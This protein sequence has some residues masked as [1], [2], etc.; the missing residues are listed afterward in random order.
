[1]VSDTPATK[2]VA[3]TGIEHRVVTY[4]KVDTAE[5]AARARGVPLAALVKTLVLRL[6]GDDYRLV[7]ISG[8]RVIDWPK[9]RR[10]LGVTRVS[11]AD[12]DALVAVTG[13]VRGTVT[14]FG[15]T[16]G[17]P[18]IV[19][20]SVL[21]HDEVSLGGGEHGVAIHL[22]PSDLVECFD[23]VVADVTKPG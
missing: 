20:A 9:V 21:E 1:M 4:G 19:D 14:P 17:W 13:Y 16:G 10:Q 22:A 18:L 6:S 8:D 3:R 5:E 12:E 2:A 11:M 15:A 7:A 23:A